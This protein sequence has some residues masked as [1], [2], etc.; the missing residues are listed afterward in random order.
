MV[1]IQLGDG[2][3]DYEVDDSFDNRGVYNWTEHVVS[4]DTPLQMKCVYGQDEEAMATRF[5]RA[6]L[7]W[8]VYDGRSCPTLDEHMLLLL[9]MVSEIYC[10]LLPIITLL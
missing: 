7:M 9:S 1:S 6:N 5:C 2:F 3:C 8:D 10:V 4:R